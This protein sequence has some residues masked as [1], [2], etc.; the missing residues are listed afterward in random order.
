MKS[1][2]LV[3]IKQ[4]MKNPKSVVYKWVSK[5]M[6]DKIINQNLNNNITYEY[7]SWFVYI[8]YKLKEHISEFTKNN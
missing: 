2:K 8:F 1:Q 6:A 5:N 4:S 7:A 3:L